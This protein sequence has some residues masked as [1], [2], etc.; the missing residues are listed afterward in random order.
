MDS[1][2]RWSRPS[3]TFWCVSS[4]TIP[5]PLSALLMT[6]LLSELSCLRVL[7]CIGV[8]FGVT[9]RGCSL[10]ICV[11]TLFR[12]FSIVQEA[13][14]GSQVLFFL[15]GCGSVDGLFLK[16]YFSLL[17]LSK[18]LRDSGSCVFGGV[19]L[20]IKVK[21]KARTS[22]CG[23]LR[24]FDER[25]VMYLVLFI[26]FCVSFIVCVWA[27]FLACL[28]LYLVEYFFETLM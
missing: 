10:L 7:V 14:G 11:L 15:K 6:K 28:F 25:F 23:G 2:E 20:G 27:V 22:N 18:L 1:S 9:L 8:R 21:P 26:S 19:Q 17:F 4:T 16:K 12:Y 24:D 5:E 3:L 13:L